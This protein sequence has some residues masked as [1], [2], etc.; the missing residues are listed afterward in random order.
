[1]GEQFLVNSANV[2][3]FLDKA[4]ELTDNHHQVL[5]EWHLSKTRT[6][7]QSRA[8]HLWMSRFADWL[9]AHG[10][11]LN[12]E[13]AIFR[14]PIQRQFTGEDVKN[15]IWK[16]VQMALFPEKKSTSQLTGNE[17]D[18]IFDAIVSR[19]EARGYDTIPPFP[20]QEVYYGDKTGRG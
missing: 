4:R 11:D 9:F 2:E 13:C 14:K 16:P 17:I 1:M 5:F 8:L 18:Q 3:K 19:F 7:R 10:L 12:L 6:S 15:L 20:K